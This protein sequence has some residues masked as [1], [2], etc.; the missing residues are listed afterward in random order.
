M[1]TH[2]NQGWI[3]VPKDGQLT[4]LQGEGDHLCTHALMELNLIHEAPRTEPAII[5][6][7]V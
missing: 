7:E 1:F 2:W 5:P 4:V 3:A 6:P